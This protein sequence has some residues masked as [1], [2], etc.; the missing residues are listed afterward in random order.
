[1]AST[2]ACLVYE[3]PSPKYSPLSSCTE[4]QNYLCEKYN[5]PALVLTRTKVAF[6]QRDLIERHC[7]VSLA[8]WVLLKYPMRIYAAIAHKVIRKIG[9]I[10]TSLHLNFRDGGDLSGIGLISCW[11]ESIY[12]DN[13]IKTQGV[14]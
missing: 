1:M 5:R 13:I 12:T 14:R 9:C 6:E 10:E 7:V 8:K 3:G 11:I 4:L 2:I